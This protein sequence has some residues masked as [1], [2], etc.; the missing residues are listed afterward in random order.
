M[1]STNKIYYF[2]EKA[3]LDKLFNILSDFNEVCIRLSKANEAFISVL[4]QTDKY[5]SCDPNNTCNLILPK[6]PSCVE[7][8]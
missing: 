6:M 3:E 4:E 8:Y 1:D 7:K 5:V 2:I